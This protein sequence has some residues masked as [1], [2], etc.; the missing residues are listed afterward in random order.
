M[1]LGNRD[2]APYP[3]YRVFAQ[4]VL[5]QKFGDAPLLQIIVQVYKTHFDASNRT[6]IKS[7]KPAKEDTRKVINVT[8]KL[9]SPSAITSISFAPFVSKSISTGGC[10]FAQSFVAHFR[11]SLFLVQTARMQFLRFSGKFAAGG[12]SD[13]GTYQGGRGSDT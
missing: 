9:F 13:F 3:K 2:R 5:A 12:T 6:T 8:P 4:M 10:C 7:R 1:T 11:Y